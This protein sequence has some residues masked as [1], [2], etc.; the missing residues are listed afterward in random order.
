MKI[1]SVKKKLL[2]YN[3]RSL[4][5][6]TLKETLHKD[7]VYLPQ[8][9]KVISRGRQIESDEILT[10][11]NQTEELIQMSSDPNLIGRIYTGWQPWI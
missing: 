2:G 1:E 8:L 11:E 7:K 3:P 9:I 5:I 6:D 10:L 4:M